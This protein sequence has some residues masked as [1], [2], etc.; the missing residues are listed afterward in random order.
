MENMLWLCNPAVFALLS[1]SLYLSLS[2]SLEA[3][4]PFFKRIFKRVMCWQLGGKKKK[5][6]EN[7]IRL[8]RISHHAV[9]RVFV[10]SRPFIN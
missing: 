7:N 6:K 5:K 2:L 9:V 4:Y 3:L 8:T 1:L 10:L